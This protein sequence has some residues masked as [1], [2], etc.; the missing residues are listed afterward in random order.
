[1]CSDLLHFCSNS[2]GSVLSVDRLTG[3]CD[4]YFRIRDIMYS[5]ACTRIC[6][7]HTTMIHDL[8]GLNHILK[9]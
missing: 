9:Q 6:L 2:D 8:K 4:S 5:T 1:M 7:S 3:K